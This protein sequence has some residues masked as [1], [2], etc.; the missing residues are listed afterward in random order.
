MVMKPLRAESDVPALT[1]PVT[2][3]LERL[4]AEMRRLSAR[5]L[6]LEGAICV[7]AAQPSSSGLGHEELQGFDLIIQTT[8]ALGTFMSHL[9]I[10]GERDQAL[11]ITPALSHLTLSDLRDRLAGHV[12][13]DAA[14][15]ASWEW[16]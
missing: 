2:D 10:D 5:L 15:E 14:E 11:V 16:F 4:A 13:S 8:T 6:K 9:A 3:V 12:L 1:T 7:L